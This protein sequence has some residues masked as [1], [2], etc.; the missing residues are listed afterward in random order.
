M[1]QWRRYHGRHGRHCRSPNIFL[2]QGLDIKMAQLDET[3]WLFVRTNSIFCSAKPLELGNWGGMATA[4]PRGSEQPATMWWRES[5][6]LD[7]KNEIVWAPW[8]LWCHFYSKFTVHRF[9]V[10]FRFFESFGTSNLKHFWMIS[11]AIPWRSTTETWS[12]T[13]RRSFFG[14]VK[15]YPFCAVEDDETDRFSLANLTGKML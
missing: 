2:Y 14:P 11:Q 13:P 4:E 5:G 15:T 8:N 10:H 3:D 7:T 6:E 9:V 1:C 12:S